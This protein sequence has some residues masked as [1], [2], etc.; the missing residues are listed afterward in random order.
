MSEPFYVNTI[1]G[2]GLQREMDISV[3]GVKEEEG[4][5]KVEENDF[6]VEEDGSVTGPSSAKRESGEYIEQ[7]ETESKFVPPTKKKK[8]VSVNAKPEVLGEVGNDN[9]GA[10]GAVGKE[11]YS[12]EWEEPE[13]RAEDGIGEREGTSVNLVVDDSDSDTIVPE[14]YEALAEMDAEY[15]ELLGKEVNFYLQTYLIFLSP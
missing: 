6:K 12:D 11:T 9:K 3:D 13:I 8:I 15:Q 1:G 14:R 7:D 10:A 4:Q 2:R 5:G